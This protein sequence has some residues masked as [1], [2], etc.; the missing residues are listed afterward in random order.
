MIVSYAPNWSVIYDHKF[1]I[2]NFY[3]TGQWRG[4]NDENDFYFGLRNLTKKERKGIKQ[5]KDRD[6]GQKGDII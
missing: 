3:S 4:K 1:T 6:K 2:V 5:K